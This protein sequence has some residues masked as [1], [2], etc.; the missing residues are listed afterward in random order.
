MLSIGKVGMSAGQ[1]MYYEQQVAKGADDY[2]AGKGEAPGRWTGRGAGLL[3]LSGGL[4]AERLKAMMD[5]RHPLT[6]ERL[7]NRSGNCSTAA[8]EMTFSA[9]KSVSVLFAVGDEELS[10]ALVAAHEE[11]VDA[12]VAYIEREACRVRRGHNGTKA[13]RERGDPR[14]WERARSEPAG[15]FVAAAYRH[16]MSRAQD[17]QL[18]THVVAANMARGADGR[19]TALDA[20]H[21]YEHAKAGG[22]VYQAHL[23]AA[24]RER[25]PWA[26]WGPVRNG[27]AELEQ[28]PAEVIGELSTRRRRI[29][30]REQELVAAGVAVGDLGRERIA[31]DTRET[32]REVNESDWRREVQARAAEH[33]LGQ[34]E[35]ERIAA[36]PAQPPAQQLSEPDLA[37]QLLGPAGLTA[38]ANTFG[39]RDVV[40]SVAAASR[41]GLRAEEVVG[42]SGRLIGSP[43]VVAVAAGSARRFMT[44]ELLAA[45][46]AIVTAA[47]KGRGRGVAVVGE[48]DALSALSRHGRLLSVEQERVVLGVAGSGNALDLERK[49][50]RDEL[51]AFIGPQ[52]AVDAEHAAIDRWTHARGAYGD[53]QAVLICRDNHRRERLN[54]LARQRLKV[55]GELGE[56]VEVAGREWCVGERVIA[57]RNDAAVTSTTAPTEPWSRS[58]PVTGCESGPTAAR[59]ARSI[60][61][62]R[63]VTWTTPTR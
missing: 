58:T 3:G 39:E 19:W 44:R 29:L 57:R 36:L 25:L 21:I 24:V 61:S 56:A 20:K 46:H 4:D 1:Q 28:V 34:A 2:Y 60:P 16:R 40:V 35:L 10:R 47:M 11:A 17:P 9:P 45:E 50:T 48:G 33:G 42:L 22:S 15:G 49:R 18:H 51:T 55:E 7:A 54:E 14:G 23:R 13:E 41:Q 38:M 8:V 53:D 12:A 59:S 6:E 32:K 30:E 26:V 31:Y 43:E 37:G 27:M 63:A 52:A 5:G 62:T